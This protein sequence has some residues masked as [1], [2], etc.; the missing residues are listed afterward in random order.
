MSTSIH[1]LTQAELDATDEVI[2]MAYNVSQSR[3]ESLL[4]YLIVQPEG[5]FVAKQQNRVVGFCNIMNY[6]PFAYVGLMSVHPAMQKQGIGHMLMEYTL[7]WI[8]RSGCPSVLL[9]ATP[10]GVPLYKHYG[11]VEDDQTLVLR[12]SQKASLPDTLPKDVFLLRE[13]DLS[14]LAAFDEPAFGAKR[15]AVLASH[16]AD[17]PQRALVTY[18]A[19]GNIAGYLIAQ[20]HVI[21]PWVA[22][23]VEDAERLLAYAL[24]FPFQ[25]VPSIFVPARNETA[26]HL[27]ER[28]GFNLERAPSHMYRGKPVQRHTALYGQASLGL[29]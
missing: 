4:R 19:R 18:D 3:K 6:G 13:E 8:D 17:D 12:Q 20:P 27:L 26:L 2:K 11:F 29:G 14:A 10:V 23:T 22:N 24:T 7:A 21:G 15:T 9:D 28:Y 1:R 5:A 16:W 25:S